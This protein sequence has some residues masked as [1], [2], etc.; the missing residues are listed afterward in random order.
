MLF[1]HENRIFMQTKN[2]ETKNLRFKLQVIFE[3]FE[4]SREIQKFLHVTNS[5]IGS[6]FRFETNKRN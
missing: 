3:S 2:D 1:F 5:R 4:T 6:I